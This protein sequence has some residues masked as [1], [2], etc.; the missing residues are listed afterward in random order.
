MRVCGDALVTSDTA[1]GTKDD[2]KVSTIDETI[3]DEV[4]GHFDARLELLAK[5]RAGSGD[6]RYRVALMMLPD[7]FDNLPE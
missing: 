6:T 5:R 7:D 4:S 1:P 3:T 2:R